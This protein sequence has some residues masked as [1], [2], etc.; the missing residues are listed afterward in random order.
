MADHQQN[1][2][3]LELIRQIT[4]GSEERSPS[5]EW[6]PGGPDPV[7]TSIETS[8]VR[9]AEDAIA[10]IDAQMRELT[11]DFQMQIGALH[12]KLIGERCKIAVVKAK[13]ADRQ[14]LGSD[15]TTIDH[16]A[17]PQLTGQK[18]AGAMDAVHQNERVPVAETGTDA[19]RPQKARPLSRMF[20]RG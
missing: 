7:L 13:A 1:T 18:G 10:D 14:G 15:A 12:E 3:V 5:S 2:D 4:S 20:R 9:N 6:T 19:G 17:A 11:A 16:Q 8:R